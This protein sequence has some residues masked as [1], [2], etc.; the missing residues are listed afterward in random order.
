M[1]RGILDKYKNLVSYLLVG[2]VTV[3]I[4]VAVYCFLV[5]FLEFETV[6]S[7]VLAW[8]ASMLFAYPANKRWVFHSHAHGRNEVSR[9]VLI[10]FACRV[11]TGIV[12]WV[13][14]YFFVDVMGL[15]DVMIK[16]YANVLVVALNY[17]A[18]KWLVFRK[19]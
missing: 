4:N 10:F 8:F 1:N 13:C 9:E 15:D 14:M 16:L 6:K 2:T 3:L 12:D 19:I 17:V 18:S 7:A 11:A 5:Y